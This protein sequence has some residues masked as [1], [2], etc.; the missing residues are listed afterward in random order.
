MRAGSRKQ[1]L[2]LETNND[3]HVVCDFNIVFEGTRNARRI[4]SLQLKAR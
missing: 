1:D 4:M 3:L 2:V